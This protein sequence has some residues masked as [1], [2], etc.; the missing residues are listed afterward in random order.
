MLAEFKN[1]KKFAVS[2]RET[3]NYLKPIYV[4][5]GDYHQGRSSYAY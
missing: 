2:K 4:R 3:R 1:T 5:E